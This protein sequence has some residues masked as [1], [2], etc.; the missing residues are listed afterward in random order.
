MFDEAIKFYNL[1]LVYQ[2]PGGGRALEY[3]GRSLAIKE[4]VSDE[5]GM[6]FSYDNIFLRRVWRYLR[7]SAT[8][9][10]QTLCERIWR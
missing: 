4:K 8:S 1:G 6:A 7:E 3:R 5:H 2:A 9:P 10:T